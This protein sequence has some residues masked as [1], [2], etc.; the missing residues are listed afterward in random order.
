ML[1]PPLMLMY[2]GVDQCERGKSPACAAFD[3]DLRQL[4]NSYDFSIF[5]CGK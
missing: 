4:F 3:S 5:A 2:S 1:C